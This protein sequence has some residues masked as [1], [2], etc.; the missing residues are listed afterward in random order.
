[1]DKHKMT[2]RD[3]C[4]K[5]ITPAIVNA[6][7]DLHRQI[8][9]EYQI[10][11]GRIIVRGNLVA[12]GTKKRADYVLFYKANL[13]IAVIEAKDNKHSIGHGIQQA[14]G[15]GE[16][17]KVPFVYSSN[18]DGFLEHDRLTGKERQIGLDEFPSPDQ[19]WNRY[20]QHNNIDSQEEELITE[21]YY[22]R[23][24]E[25]TPRYYQMNAINETIKSVAK[26]QNR[27][28]L[29]MAT[30][31]GKTY[32]AFQII[33]R[34]WKARKAK[35]ILFLADRN[36]LVDQTMNQDFKPFKSV[37]TKI[38]NR[39]IDTS[40]E[41]YLGLYQAITGPNEEDKIYKQVPPSFFDLIVIDECHRGSAKEDSQWRE[42]IEY[43][44]DAVQVGLTATPK[45]T[46]DVSNIGYF[47]EPVY[48]YSLK[49]GIEDG[50]LAPYKVYRYGFDK[51]LMGFRPKKGQLDKDGKVIEDRIYNTMDF[52]TNLVLEKRTELVAKVISDF[53]KKQD[54]FMKTIVFCIDI[55]HAERMR[56]ALVNE[57]SDLVKEDPR[58]VMKITGDDNEGKAQ[59]DNFIDPNSKYPTIVTT[60]K[61]LTT[62]V[63]AKTCKVVAIDSR[64]ES[65][66]EFKQI[67]GRGTRI[68][69]KHDKLYFNLLDF[70]DVSNK[71]ADPDFDGD[72]IPV[73][74]G[75]DESG[76]N[77]KSDQGKGGRTGNDGND[78][79]NDSGEGTEL[80]RKIY[81]NDVEV[82]LL[83][84]RVQYYDKD[85]KLVTESLR[86][87]SKRNIKEEFADLNEFLRRWN[88]EGRKEAIIEE[89]KEHGVILDA[90]R[91]E[92][93][94]N[95]IDDFDLICHIAYDMKPLTR[96]ERANNVKK[97]NYFGKYSE[98]AQKVLENLLEKYMN[99][100]VY[101]LD[102]AKVLRIEP[103]CEIGKPKDLIQAFG[104]KSG[105][106]KAIK[107]LERELFD[108]S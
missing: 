11:D 35:R 46:E 48:T 91:E 71:F 105:W 20:K 36:I 34:L 41:V 37:M 80:R 83:H 50:F 42:I 102:D 28:L 5:Y 89:L 26:G 39:K 74:N 23:L 10:T 100:G 7:W 57:N 85:G 97:R 64:I 90:L 44:S 12:R 65:M 16:M 3:I 61:L 27:I 73:D 15:Y 96:K 6:G 53:L 76:E 51:D 88:S 19:L 21:P 49:E 55:E 94:L 14:I 32:T 98:V 33:Y 62:G 29:V 45:E 52:D 54:R 75:D 38:K 107:E 4:T 2:E 24:G 87:Y 104:G 31:T 72:P 103:F 13:P 68:N 9:E 58:Y 77:G 1:M 67:L 79:G 60:S 81:V 95:E 84:E 30:G 8:R 18:G 106:N 70:R 99:E 78:D 47:G 56:Q 82:I 25:K 59:L 101:N 17:L 22:F 69:E 92:T 93:G 43:F 108:I 86:D 63:D 66:I 40:Y